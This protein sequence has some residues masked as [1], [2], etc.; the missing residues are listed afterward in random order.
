[1]RMDTLSWIR[2]NQTVKLKTTNKKFFNQY[3]YK[4]KLR[5][6][7]A[8]CIR[9]GGTL[10]F[11]ELVDIVNQRKKILE[12]LR[13]HNWAGSWFNYDVNYTKSVVLNDLYSVILLSQKYQDLINVR[14]EEPFLTVYSNSNDI[15]LELCSK[16]TSERILEIYFPK[17]D[18]ETELL[19]TG[20]L[21]TNKGLE[22][23]YRIDVRTF[24]FDSVTTKQKILFQ[25]ENLG[26]TVDISYSTRKK[27]LSGNCYF[28]GGG[29]IYIKDE[30]TLIYLKLMC[31]QIIGK[32]YNLSA[33]TPLNK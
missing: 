22:F 1:M 14:I 16:F 3:L 30:N 12:H 6:P 29:R 4:V 26:D 21:I 7:F 2:L 10:N 28:L 31:P 25:L 5:C 8:G 9:G 33:P 24:M 23:Q 27:L 15:L 13:K 11:H 19:Q 32:I 20:N 18:E 17:N